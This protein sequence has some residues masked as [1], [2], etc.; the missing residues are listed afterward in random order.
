MPPGIIGV[1]LLSVTPDFVVTPENGNFGSANEDFHGGGSCFA[2]GES[3]IHLVFTFGNNI[4][5]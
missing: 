5:H 3:K 1:M 4:L 2:G